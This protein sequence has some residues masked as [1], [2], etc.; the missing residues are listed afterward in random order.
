MGKSRGSGQSPGTPP[1]GHRN[2]QTPS[3]NNSGGRPPSGSGLSGG[4]GNSS[5][6][7]FYAELDRCWGLLER[8]DLDGAQS[9]ALQLL[10]PYALYSGAVMILMQVYYTLDPAAGDSAWAPM[11]LYWTLFTLR[12]I[13][14]SALA[15]FAARLRFCSPVSTR[16]VGEGVS[17]A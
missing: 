6:E 11:H 10:L 3:S 7:K 2:G 14:H 15:F 5:V 1:N 13:V 16:S 12:I 17:Q 9:L 8:G 4:G